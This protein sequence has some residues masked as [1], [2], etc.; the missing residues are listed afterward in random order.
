MAFRAPSDGASG[1][2]RRWVIAGVSALIVLDVI[3]V[4]W[5]V[6][7]PGSSEAESPSPG[8]GPSNV[9]AES[10][11]PSASDDGEGGEGGEG[12]PPVAVEAAATVPA[13]R[14]LAAIDADRAWRAAT[15]EC[16]AAVAAPEYST[17]GGASW[18][19]T[20]A[21]GPTGVTAL[22]RIIASSTEV[23]SM[24]GAAAESCAPTLIRTY[25]R[26]DNYEEYP[27]EIGTAWHIDPA[28]RARVVAPDGAVDAP[29]AA[30]VAV[31]PENDSVA[32][33][34]CADGTVSTTADAGVTW[35]APV[36]VAG[37]QSIDAV[38]GGFLVARLGG[39][40]CAG[41]G[42]ALV[43]A[44]PDDT[45]A[46]VADAGCMP[47]AGDLAALAGQVAVSGGDG[48]W[49][50]WAGDVLARSTDRGATWG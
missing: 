13:T 46:T 20:D 28:D 47:V 8:P 49:W 23:A 45:A 38:E 50:V 35:R 19:P 33:V 18:V 10:P 29:C 21:T 22:Q 25:V 27:A 44:G 24:V 7:R 14:I 26:G 36:A 39:T 40:A 2:R 37:A 9:A 30:A 41:V 16:P 12:E 1:R 17:D 4:A 5:V 15:G 43:G 6:S 42:L 3:L 31:A 11:S 32:A 34:L 48:A